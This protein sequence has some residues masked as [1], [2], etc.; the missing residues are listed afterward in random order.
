M[1]KIYIAPELI[2]VKINPISMLCESDYIPGGDSEETG[3]A[4]TKEFRFSSIWE[5]DRKW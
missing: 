2:T 3:Y 1:K 5:E 4:E